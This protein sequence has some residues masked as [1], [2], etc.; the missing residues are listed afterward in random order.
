MQ[1]FLGPF[2]PYL[3]DAFVD[4]VRRYK[5]SDRLVPLL[6]LVPSDAIRR[7]LK[8]LLVLDHGLD[9]INFQILTFHQLSRQLYEE[10]YG[11]SEPELREDLFLEESL[12]SLIRKDYAAGSP[13]SGLDEMEGGCAAL[14]QT[15]RDLKDGL[16]SPDMVIQAVKEGHFGTGAIAELSPL[17]RLSLDFQEHCKTWSIRDYTDLD[18][19]VMDQIPASRFLKKF[20]HI[21]HYGFY[22]LTQVQTEQ[23]QSVARHYAT[24][25][26]FPLLQG[27]PGWVFAQRFYDRSV[28]TLVSD[29]AQVTDL[30]QLQPDSGS[31]CDH[32]F[33]EEV[34][35]EFAEAQTTG[36]SCTI[37]SCS[38][39]RDETLT[40]A[41]EI[42]RLVSDEGISFGDIG[43]V[44]RNLSA[45]A[46][47]IMEIF[48]DHGIPVSSSAQEPVVRHPLAK[49]VLLLT[50]L[51]SKDYI[52]S[53]VIDLLSS[54]YLNT[55]E[56]CPEGIVPRPDLWESLTRR[57]GVTRGMDKWKRLKQFIE[58]E[59]RRGQ[60]KDRDKGN[61]AERLVQYKQ[62]RC[63]WE[64]FT[65][66]QQNLSD[67]PARAEWSDYAEH[68]KRLFKKYLNISAVEE[69]RTE[70]TKGSEWNKEDD[71]CEVILDT[72]ENLAALDAVISPISMQHFI[73]TFTR[74]LERSSIAIADQNIS[75]VS[76][77][78]AMAARGLHFKVLFLLGINEGIF[79]RTIREDAFL[80]DGHRRT[81]DAT[82][83]Y[84]VGEKLAGYDEEKLLF[85]LLVG[86]AG[87]RLYCLYQRSDEQGKPLAP[88]WYLDEL[89]KG[90]GETGRV[91]ERVI[92]RG[93]LEKREVVPFERADLHTPQELS[94]QLAMT[95]QDP[96]P[97]FV[98]LP[99][100][101][102]LYVHGLQTLKILEDE[103]LLCSYDGMV[104]PLPDHWKSVQK[105]GVSP[106]ALE[107]YAECPFQYFGTKILG[108]RL[109]DRPEESAG[110]EPAD[111]GELC[112][113][114]LKQV[115]EALM[116]QVY[117]KKKSTDMDCRDIREVRDTIEGLSRK[118]FSK[119]E[120]DNPVSYPVV[121]ED[122]KERIVDL[123]EEVIQ[124]DRSH[125]SQSGDAPI[126]LEV[127]CEGRLEGVWPNIPDFI[128]EMDIQG[129]IDRID[130]HEE[131][132]RYRVIDYKY[133]TGKN[134]STQ[135]KNLMQAAVRGQRLQPPLYLLLAKR[136]AAEQE[137]S[138]ADFPA[139][140]AFYFL[141]PN[142]DKG[143]IVVSKFPANGWEGE[144]GGMLK[145]TFTLLLKG[146]Q[147]GRF[148]ILPGSHCDYCDLSTI[149]RMNHLQS[150][151]RAVQD[152]L[153][154]EH[155]ALRTVKI[156]KKKPSNPKLKM[157][158]S[159]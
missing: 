100:S 17:L 25:L 129:R 89:R 59:E 104:G 57:I 20:H 46:R 155:Q 102:T 106:T 83:G 126:A 149:C 56:V 36:A 12:R 122:L 58:R 66:L 118:I 143:P 101:Q 14:W 55:G 68:W 6:V 49:A 128:G 145:N 76:V 78:D 105:K 117:F 60:G 33:S 87:E 130:Y 154:Q 22:D 141:A 124:Y 125:L 159:R 2:H 38:G 127:K 7:R 152:P 54:P 82:L 34:S 95:S 9:L 133:K 70:G 134:Q 13:F 30:L 72:L 73:E 42:L 97:L 24:T 44:A 146:I 151:R 115:Y 16:V 11:S 113:A 80:R 84:K 135:D 137:I 51:S 32:L 69:Q 29:P 53:E 136:Y 132:K 90:L 62:A 153:T 148:F 4:E 150:K 18:N 112:H 77:M 144:V 40:V 21:F 39:E 47:P 109:L 157:D 142:W 48:T 75:G 52:R 1:V 61:N 99:L 23:F 123:I 121:W 111:T 8:T 79:P 103:E 35:E 156:S 64:V 158:R 43:I 5:S 98:Q 67:L 120:Q 93:L 28:Q 81:M 110:L 147:E 45:Y 41:K 107:H 15:L 31:I 74:W 50:G 139:E 131:K 86:A 114:I 71:I 10:Q 108:L 138:K 3:E 92:P 140:A 116:A 27:H 85:S 19:M 37:I 63:L 91:R 26:F 119:Y 65:R 94:L 88:S 96:G